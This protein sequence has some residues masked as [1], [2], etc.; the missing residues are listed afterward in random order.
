M[1]ALTDSKSVAYLQLHASELLTEINNTHQ[2]VAI[3]EN[4]ET[5]AVLQDLQSYEDMR[6]AI[7]L[8]KLIAQS[9]EDVRMGRTITQQELETEMLEMFADRDQEANLFGIWVDRDD[10][11]NVDDYVHHL[12]K[13]RFV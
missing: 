8:L 5:K 4:G 2:A 7:S 1:K 10:I 12:R 13:A 3:T 11:D 9:E 6:N